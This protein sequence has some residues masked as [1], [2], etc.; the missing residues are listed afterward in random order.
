[1]GVPR[2]TLQKMQD[3]GWASGPLIHW[4]IQT[5]KGRW[6]HVCQQHHASSLKF[7]IVCV[8]HKLHELPPK[9][10][11]TMEVWPW[12]MSITDC[13]G[14]TS[15]MKLA[16]SHPAGTQG[17]G[18]RPHCGAQKGSSSKLLH[19]WDTLAQSTPTCGECG[20]RNNCCCQRLTER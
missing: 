8:L 19:H 13:N 5:F 7:L 6:P 17:S 12:H 1:M 3:P 2:P 16:A 11:S 9:R 14:R 10:L 18:T 20:H 4:S 15:G